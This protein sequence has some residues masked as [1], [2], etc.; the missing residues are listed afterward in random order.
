MKPLAHL[1]LILLL[2]LLLVS[3]AE[4]SELPQ[5]VQGQSQLVIEGTI[6]SGRFPV[7]MLSESALVDTELRSLDDLS[8][9]I[10]L[11]ARVSISDGEKEVVLTGI[12]DTTCF[13]P[14]IYTTPYMRGEPGKTYTI[15]AS[16][17]GMTA[18][19]SAT[20][21]PPAALSAIR[22]EKAS[23]ENRYNII[24]SLPETGFDYAG[25]YVMRTGTDNNYLHSFLSGVDATSLK[26]G[27][28]EVRV[29]PGRS[30]LYDGNDMSYASGERVKVKFVTM[31]S[32]GRDFWD[33]FDN[34]TT[35]GFSPLFP[36]IANLPTNVVSGLGYWL[37]YGITE[38][39]VLIP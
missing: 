11:W 20:I 18:S 38:Y 13:P 29:L 33:E 9:N 21:P 30:M 14:Y 28:R 3:A 8:D 35:L 15:K 37:G 1:S 26:G 4:C 7:V 34:T 36:K 22:A 10:L 24:A 5:I 27:S 17:R 12:K 25:F 32:F 39:E 16:G 31:D 19:A 23:E 2:P 6:E